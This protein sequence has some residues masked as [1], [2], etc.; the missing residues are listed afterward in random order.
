M[1]SLPRSFELDLVGIGGA[2]RTPE[3]GNHMIGFT[4]RASCQRE[5]SSLDWNVKKVAVGSAVRRPLE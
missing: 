5:V 3:P 4:L 2:P 1:H